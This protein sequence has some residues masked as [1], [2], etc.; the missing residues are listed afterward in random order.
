MTI[1][2]TH[3]KRYKQ[4]IANAVVIYLLSYSSS[5]AA[6]TLTRVLFKIPETVQPVALPGAIEIAGDTLD[7]YLDRKMHAVGNAVISRDDQKIYGDVIEYNMLNDELRAKGNVRI[8][9]GDGVITGPALK[10]RLTDTIGE[11]KNAS[12][13]LKTTVC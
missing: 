13:S 4:F 10:M 2:R 9:L 8:E 12:I 6:E 7:L 11:M 5:P 3:F 1:Y